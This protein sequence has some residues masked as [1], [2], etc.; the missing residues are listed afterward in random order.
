MAV[1][2]V[3]SGE[4]YAYALHL[5]V[6]S[7]TDCRQLHIDVMC[8][9][10][11]WLQRTLTALLQ[12]PPADASADVQQRILQLRQLVA[13]ADSFSSLRKVLSHAHGTLHS[14][15]C[16]VLHGCWGMTPAL[17]SVQRLHATDDVCLPRCCGFFVRTPLTPSAHPVLMQVLWQPGWTDGCA[18]TLG[19]EGEQFFS[20]WSKYAFTTRNQSLAGVHAHAGSVS[21]IFADAAHDS[22]CNVVHWCSHSSS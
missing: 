10:G 8:K 2:L 3:G 1:N 19:E 13:D 22:S 17:G 21:R 16:Q 12:A 5:L 20:Y 6:F 18:K 9:W 11:P 7:L 14:L 15:N 4:R